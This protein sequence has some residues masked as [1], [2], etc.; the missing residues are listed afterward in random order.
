ME[1]LIPWFELGPC[2]I[3]APGIVNLPLHPFGLLMGLGAVFGAHVLKWKA[4][5]DGL[6]PKHTGDMIFHIIVFALIGAHLLDVLI[7]HPGYILEDPLVLVR[8]WDGLSSFGGFFGA[9][10]G[11]Y[12]WHLRSGQPFLPYAD[13]AGFSFPFGMFFGRLGCFVVHDHP[14]SVSNFFLAV[15]N[16]RLGSPPFQPRHDLGLYE[17]IWCFFAALLFLLLRQRIRPVGFFL[18][19]VPVLYSPIRFGLDFLRAL[20]SESPIDGDVRYAL[21][22]P[23]QWWSLAFFI[24]GVWLFWRIHSRSHGAQNLPDKAKPSD[25]HEHAEPPSLGPQL[26]A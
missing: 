1:L 8:F 10:V 5:Q 6:S 12:I 19:L 4:K 20:P 2:Y 18:A 11:V 7:Y 16:F 22:T 3:N 25:M 21:L 23:G 14:G 17:A 13:A 26:G 15:D 24:V 9:V